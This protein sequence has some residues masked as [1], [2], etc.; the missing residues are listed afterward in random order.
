MT[1]NFHQNFT[2][3]W[4]YLGLQTNIGKKNK[5]M[6]AHHTFFS[7]DVNSIIQQYI[8]IYVYG[9]VFVSFLVPEAECKKKTRYIW[10]VHKYDWDWKH[11]REIIK[12]GL[13]SCPQA[14][15]SS[16]NILTALCV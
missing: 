14:A 2:H 8:E 15:F 9:N 12:I 13:Q 5:L 1:S 10:N 3:Q 7:S 16:K 4:E 11:F 6:Y